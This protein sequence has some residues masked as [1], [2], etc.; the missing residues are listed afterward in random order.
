VSTAPSGPLA[1]PAVHGLALAV[2]AFDLALAAV[3]A[4][5]RGSI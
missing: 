2:S 5:D 1:G 4:Q 3:T